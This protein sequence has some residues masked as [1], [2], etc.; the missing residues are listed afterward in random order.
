MR[1]L[2]AC[3]VVVMPVSVQSGAHKSLTSAS[4]A[5]RA[6]PSFSWRTWTTTCTFWYPSRIYIFHSLSETTIPRRQFL[7]SRS[8]HRHLHSGS[9][10]AEALQ[11]MAFYS[12]SETDSGQVWIVFLKVPYPIVY[13]GH[14]HV[15]GQLSPEWFRVET[16]SL[17]MQACA[18]TT[19]IL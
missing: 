11:E 4:T 15:P 12:G 5:L 1:F 13:V 9:L 6:F 7:P 18:H 14:P 10:T 17:F 3:S 19:S 8:V 2:F 16:Q